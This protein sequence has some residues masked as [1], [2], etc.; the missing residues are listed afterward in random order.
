[1]LRQISQ[2]HGHVEADSLA[3]FV[4]GLLEAGIVNLA[5]MIFLSALDQEINLLP[6]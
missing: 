4:E 6:V 2:K 3:G 5:L 1:M